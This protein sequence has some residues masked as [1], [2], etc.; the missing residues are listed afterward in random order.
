M[1]NGKNLEKVRW[2]STGL[3]LRKFL[4]VD[5][6]LEQEIREAELGG[7]RAV[8]LRGHH[9]DVAGANRA[10]VTELYAKRN[11]V[12]AIVERLRSRVG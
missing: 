9:S 8:L 7:A 1:I 6:T 4:E 2:S 10:H 5:T 3:R 11:R 12:A